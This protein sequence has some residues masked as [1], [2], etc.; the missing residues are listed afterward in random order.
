MTFVALVVSVG[1]LWVAQCV[2]RQAYN[3]FVRYADWP[4]PKRTLPLAGNIVEAGPA[5]MR[6]I[7]R[8]AR[9]HASKT[10][11]FL[12]WPG[13]ATPIAVVMTP[14]AVREVLSSHTTFP[15]GPDYTNT[16]GR[17]FGAGLVTSTGAQHSR[18][19]RCLGRFFVKT[20][21]E[22]ELATIRDVAS[23]VAEMAIEPACGDGATARVD[24]QECF[25][26]ITLQ[27]FCKLQLSVDVW[28]LGTASCP[29]ALHPS[30]NSIKRELG[31]ALDEPLPP[32]AVANVWSRE[33]SFGSNVVG[34]H[35]IFGIPLSRIFPDVRRTIRSV[36]DAHDVFLALAA[37]RK[38]MIGDPD[39]PDD[40]LTALV[41]EQMENGMTDR[42]ICDQI[43]TLVS[44]G[45]D[46][47]A[48]F[49]C[50]AIFLLAKHPD[51]AEDLRAE[52]NDPDAFDFPTSRL[53]RVLQEVLRLYPTIPMVTR[54]AASDVV[55]SAANNAKMRL[56]RGSR[57]LVPFFA[58]N[59]LTSVWGDDAA[60]F[61]P[62]RWLEANAEV[63]SDGIQASKQGF[64]PFSYGSR[65]CIGYSF[66][67]VETRA[68]LAQLLDRY[69]FTEIPGFSPTIKA[70]ISLTVE[71]P[72]GIRVQVR[73][74]GA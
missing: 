44:A 11:N 12:F 45:H 39:C 35:M 68:I 53:K 73:H 23:R 6:Y 33:V 48:Y 74:R 72:K 18:A 62:G 16:F 19:R 4:S 31:V 59:R 50:Y 30:L 71:N 25:H 26:M 55:I 10:G 27:V 8:E 9:R 47:T 64:L 58:I 70:G 49:C 60:V 52:L 40:C 29:L 66:A 38:A 41:K 51:L 21:V 15:K 36:R 69:V 67:L 42:E 7:V 34:T 57:I 28:T 37:R 1:L 13:G 43:L 17:V 46:T 56:P 5:F 32:G 14:K 2:V 24:L 3:R 20:A 63:R 22:A 65:T 61:N 54:V